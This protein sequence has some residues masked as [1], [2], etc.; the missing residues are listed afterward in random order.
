VVVDDPDEVLEKIDVIGPSLG[1]GELVILSNK[2]LFI[3]HQQ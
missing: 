3:D 1:L 2:A